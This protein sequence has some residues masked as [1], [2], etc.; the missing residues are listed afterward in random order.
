MCV[1]VCVALLEKHLMPFKIVRSKEL[2]GR[3]KERIKKT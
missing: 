3:L 1:C 2:L